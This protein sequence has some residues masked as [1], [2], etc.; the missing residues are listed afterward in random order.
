M[1]YIATTECIL[2]EL[3]VNSVGLITDRQTV[4]LTHTNNCETLVMRRNT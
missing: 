4:Y 1:V 2:C 3:R